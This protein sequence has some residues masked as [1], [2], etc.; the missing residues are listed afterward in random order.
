MPGSVDDVFAET[1]SNPV[2]GSIEIVHCYSMR[3]GLYGSP[4]EAR[5]Y[6]TKIDF[7]EPDYLR[8]GQ[9]ENIRTIALPTKTKIEQFAVYETDK[10]VFLMSQSKEFEVILH[11][12][13]GPTVSD[14]PLRSFTFS[15][16]FG[17]SFNIEALMIIPEAEKVFFYS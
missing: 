7:S 4:T 13:P 3:N 15:P 1:F 2:D 8:H 12:I 16:L 11:I 5:I 10:S 6:W 9:A 14:R 17:P